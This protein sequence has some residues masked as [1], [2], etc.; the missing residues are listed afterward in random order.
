MNGKINK[1][2][3]TVENH[4][5]YG[6][7]S[8]ENP[9]IGA[10]VLSTKSCVELRFAYNVHAQPLKRVAPGAYFAGGVMLVT[11]EFAIANGFADLIG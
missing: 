9:T 5:W 1:L 10:E 8:L 7:T 11:G 6:L 4:K 3:A 2:G